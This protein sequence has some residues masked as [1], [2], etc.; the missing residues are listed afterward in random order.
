MNWNAIKAIVLDIDG[1]LTDGHIGYAGPREIKFFHV[2]DGH[3]LK[4]AMRAGLK[5]GVLSGRSSE[6]NRIRAK[7]LGFDFMYEGKKDK[8][9]AFG[10]LL[11]EQGLQAEECLY[12][13]D[14]VVDIPVLRQAGIAVTVA[15]AP[16]IMDEFCQERTRARG[17]CGAV[18]EIVELLLK[19]QNKWQQQMERYLS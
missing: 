1:V 13:G 12:M 18:R 14:D 17:G 10:E 11:A 5:V 8:R 4:M 3:G 16:E 2:R 6:A 9:T 7:E 19:K 15:D